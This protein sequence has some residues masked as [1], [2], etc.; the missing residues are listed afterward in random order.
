[1]TIKRIRDLGLSI[2]RFPT[3]P[4]N[5]ITDVPGILVGQRTLVK[6]CP[7]VVRTGVSVILPQNGFV[8]TRYPMAGYF[9]F[10][11][12]GEMTGLSL[13]DEWGVLTSPI[14]LTNTNQVGMAWNTVSQYGAQKFGGFVYKLPVVAETYDGELN[15]INTYPLNEEDVIKA[16]ESAVSGPVQEGNVGGGT[17]MTCYDFKGGIGTSSRLVEIFGVS[18][19][20]GVF[21]Q[22]NHGRR[23]QLMIDGLAVGRYFD[24]HRVPAPIGDWE[25]KESSSILVIIATDA[26]LIPDQ[27]RRLAKRATVGLARTGGVGYNTSGDL[28]LAFATGNSYDPKTEQLVELRMLPQDQMDPLIEATADML[29]RS[30]F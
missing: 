5:A 3:G 17:G 11:G 7:N 12:I 4:F 21:V 23:H 19:I 29:L 28:F 2:G 1:M 16:L 26:P 20:V 13:I 24:T 30:R 22:A 25:S 6:D 27:C 15:D 18:Y 14:V 9:I 8:H 10:N